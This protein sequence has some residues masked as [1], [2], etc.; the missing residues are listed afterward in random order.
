MTLEIGLVL[1]ILAMAVVLFVSEKLRVDVVALLVLL[2]VAFTGLVE[3]RQALSGFSNPAVVTV[4]AVFI[5]SGGL[6]RT[7]VAGRVG[8]IVLRLAGK[9]EIGLV[10]AI[11]LTAGSL[12]AFM[13]NVGVA[14]LLLPVVMDI[15]GRTR[16]APSKLLIPLAFSSLLG[17]LITMIGTPPNILI[18]DASKELGLTPFGLFDYTP[19][20]LAVM[21]AGIAYM[22]FIGRHLLP[23]RDPARLTASANDAD[24]GQLYELRQRLAVLSLAQGSALA[25]R[26]LAESR[27]G[28]ALGVNVLG[29]VRG[30]RTHLA[31]DRLTTLEV[32]DRLL[33]DGRLDRLSELRGQEYLD[34]EEESRTLIQLMSP[35]LAFREVG[36]APGS[37]AVG[38]TLR[39]LDFRGRFGV[40]VVALWRDGKVRR[41]NLAN[42]A[43]AGGDRLLVQGTG[44]GARALADDP[45]FTVL[46]TAAGTAA[47]GLEERLMIVHV[48]EGSTLLGKTLR[49]ARLGDAFGLIVLGIARDGAQGLVT[50]PQAEL[51]VGDILLVE[52]NP[53]DLRTVQGLRQLEVDS[54]A[55]IPD[56]EQLE[57]AHVGFA[58]AVLS[59]RTELAGQTLKELHFRDKWGLNV[60]AILREGEEIRQGLRNTPLRAG[61]AL[62]LY[63]SRERLKLL[64]SEPDFIV[65][66]EEAQKP[67]LLAKAPI[68]A[69]VMAA[70]VVPVLFGWIP[71]YLSAIA[72]ATLMVLTRCLTMDEAYRFIEWRAVFLIAGMLPLGLAMQQSGAAEYLTEGVV[73]AVGGLGPMGVI[74]A[75]YLVT[76]FGAQVMPT[77]AVA[78]LM[79]PIAFNTAGD[80]G[81]SPYATLMT[82]ALSASASFM[83][84]VAHPANV[85]IMGPGGYRF[86]DYI[87]VGLPLTLVCLAV[88]LLILPLVWPLT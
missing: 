57:S 62:L 43:L 70:V 48:P 24:L 50:G 14:A 27:L 58:E 86:S 23:D 69:L 34:F 51:Q 78:I 38:R 54:Q 39:Q 45:D 41:L 9:S 47:Y 71:I 68:A 28:S 84:P 53:E 82:V 36:V 73:S 42:L 3:P 87:K 13:N 16:I 2:S 56:F 52:G 8:H 37:G 63:G 60:L 1:A 61:D 75:L 25:G 26:T 81:I 67:P 46:E 22:V 40:S 4:W 31:P 32:G 10:A 83:S 79:A 76:A 77:A 11:M 64:G 5:L 20:G 12:S 44:E 30:G 72:G 18:S 74:A 59:P 33:V 15:S 80:L 17:G 55:S 6:S 21:L 88:V 35:E 29:F 49:E 65:L 19:V 66:T 85:L 7:G